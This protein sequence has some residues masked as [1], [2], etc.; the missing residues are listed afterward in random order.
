MK[1]ER[2]L[3]KREF[4]KESLLNCKKRRDKALEKENGEP[5]KSKP[6]K[7]DL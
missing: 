5:K 1:K 3:N 7:I 2:D 4:K 6:S